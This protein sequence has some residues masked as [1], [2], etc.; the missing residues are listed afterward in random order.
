MPAMLAAAIFF[1]GWGSI[2]SRT[3]RTLAKVE[4]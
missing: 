3:P 2:C 4:V 1:V